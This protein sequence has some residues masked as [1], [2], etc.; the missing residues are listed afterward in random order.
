MGTFLPLASQNGTLTIVLQLMICGRFLY[1]CFFSP[2]IV[3][4]LITGI[5]LIR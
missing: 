1:F 5:F 2:V 3:V 4:Q